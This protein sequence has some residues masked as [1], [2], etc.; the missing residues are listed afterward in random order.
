MYVYQITN[1][2]NGKIY[3]GITND[4]IKRWS[5][6]RCCNSPNM[7][8]ARAI[9]K[10][11]VEHFKFEVLLSGLSV[12]EADEKE[13][14]LIIEKNCRVPYGYNVAILLYTDGF[15]FGIFILYKIHRFK[16]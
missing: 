14:E 2:I 7:V 9:K 3:I 10:Y 8:L 15:L 11:G 13:E 5:N 16:L 4:Y 6:H 12:E 1:L